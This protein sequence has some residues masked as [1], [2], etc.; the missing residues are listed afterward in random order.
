MITKCAAIIAAIIMLMGVAS[1]STIHSNFTVNNKDSTMMFY[2]YLKEPRVE[3]SGYERGYKAG[4]LNYLVDG[5]INFKDDLT[6]YDGKVDAAHRNE[7]WIDRNATLRHTQSVEFDGRKG[8]SEFYA[9]GFFP[10]NRAVSAW[11]KIRYDELGGYLL[12]PS[13]MS[14][15]INVK[16]DVGMGP[17]KVTGMQSDY[18]FTYH[19]DVEDGALEIWD[20]T[21][22][23]NETGARRVDWEQTAFMKGR[24][25]N[26][27]NNLQVEDLF[28]PGGG[29]G[30]DW[31]PCVVSTI[32][33]SYNNWPS[34]ATYAVL[35]PAQKLPYLSRNYN[36]NATSGCNTSSKGSIGIG[37][38]SAEIDLMP[39][40]NSPFEITGNGRKSMIPSSMNTSQEDCASS[41]C[42]STKK[43]S[44]K[45][46]TNNLNEKSTSDSIKNINPTKIIN[47]TK[48]NASPL[49]AYAIR[50]EG[51]PINL[52]AVKTRSVSAK[53]KESGC[54]VPEGCGVSYSSLSCTYCDCP[55]YEGIYSCA[56][57]EGGMPGAGIA[58]ISTTTAHKTKQGPDIR[59][60]KS[61]IESKD[62]IIYTIRV[63]N[64]GGTGLNDVNLTDILPKGLQYW[65]AQLSYENMQGSTGL[66]EK[67]PTR[68]ANNK[69]E[70]ILFWNIGDL[71]I[72][73]NAVI[74][75][76]VKRLVSTVQPNANRAIAT[77]NWINSTNNAIVQVKDETKIVGKTIQPNTPS[78]L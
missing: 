15:K 78:P 39:D 72:N 33:P 20:A 40:I 4:S 26:V 71:G 9:K 41:V 18:D 60:T 70:G 51:S 66:V 52:G 13:A 49:V 28:F 55:G 75:L 61:Y 63:S 73:E 27:T 56:E 65:D 16:A 48:I 6:Y 3:E 76:T 54:S 24:I 29:A 22:W 25:L 67:G 34:A 37:I 36:C 59:V 69:T 35:T 68:P 21:G 44:N 19:A 12:G 47:S 10:S 38:I 2:S 1:A 50:S 58:G 30:I 62:K 53:A 11:K 32:A 7:T 64:G 42:D 17:A 8:I 57:E 5:N 45:I 23:T 77:G 74:N 46:E 14:S 43:G 31:L